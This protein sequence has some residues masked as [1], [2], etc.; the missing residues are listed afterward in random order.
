MDLPRN[1]PTPDPMQT[2]VTDSPHHALLALVSD[3]ARPADLAVA[4]NRKRIDATLD[5]LRAWL[6]KTPIADWLSAWPADSPAEQRQAARAVL[7]IPTRVAN[8]MQRDAPEFFAPLLFATRLA[9]GINDALVDHPHLADRIAVIVEIMAM[10]GSVAPLVYLL[11]RQSPAPPAAAWPAVLTRVGSTVRHRVILDAL[12]HAA[13][14][15]STSPARVSAT[16]R[17]LCSRPLAAPLLDPLVSLDAIALHQVARKSIVRALLDDGLVVTH[18]VAWLH[19]W[20]IPSFAASHS[21]RLFLHLTETLLLCAGCIEVAGPAGPCAAVAPHVPVINEALYSGIC[22]ALNSNEPEVRVPA[23]VLAETITARILPTAVDFGL[24][25]DAPEV[26]HLRGLVDEARAWTSAPPVAVAT[27][28]APVPTPSKAPSTMP[29]PGRLPAALADSDDEDSDTDVPAAPSAAAAPLPPKPKPIPLFLRDCLDVLRTDG[30]SAKTTPLN[31]SGRTTDADRDVQL[32]YDVVLA[33]A[34]RVRATPAFDVEG[35]ADALVSHLHLNCH[36][37]FDDEDEE[38]GAD[39]VG[40]EKRFTQARIQAILAVGEK[41]PVLTIQALLKHINQRAIISIPKQLEA[42]RLVALLAHRLAFGAPP[43]ADTVR[44]SDLPNLLTPTASSPDPDA[45]AIRDTPVARAVGRTTRRLTPSRPPAGRANR[46]AGI[47]AH[48]VYPLLG[49]ATADSDEMV[50][51]QRLVA[52]AN[53]MYTTVHLPETWTLVR[54]V[55]DWA[56]SL[57]PAAHSAVARRALLFAYLVVLEANADRP[58]VVVREVGAHLQLIG[59]WVNEWRDDDR[60]ADL[61]K[62]LR[63]LAM[64]LYSAQKGQEAAVLSAVLSR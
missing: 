15:P 12:A 32:V 26:V 19:M 59:H 4:E 14:D 11:A 27:A 34:D 37:P 6:L 55:W 54:D 20:G 36:S 9:A 7:S 3:L 49:L 18:L 44:G 16:L 40:A 63:C 10:Q 24:P 57:M 45:P 50:F 22:V 47:A 28:P 64:T 1:G 52:L 2:H 29:R 31:P 8:L 43:I 13:A 25:R 5:R 48:F 58:A 39:R 33:L 61:V 21:T 30:A 41:C 38:A 35:V 23:Q 17:A 62:V 56:L 51:E 60:D 42:F 53:V 46:M